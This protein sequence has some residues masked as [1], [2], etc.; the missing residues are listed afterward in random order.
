MPRTR[1]AFHIVFEP[2]AGLALRDA[3]PFQAGVAS[4]AHALP[5][6]PPPGPFWAAGRDALKATGALRPGDHFESRG[7]WLLK[8]GERYFPAPLDLV[9]TLDDRGNPAGWTVMAPV[10]DPGK[11]AMDA[12]RASYAA[13]D[14]TEEDWHQGRVFAWS[15]EQR[16]V[17]TEGRFMSAAQWRTYLRGTA[18]D[19]SLDLKPTEEFKCADDVRVGTELAGRSAKTGRLYSEPVTFLTKG[20]QFEIAAEI[21]S[22]EPREVPGETIVR[23]GGEAKI[24]SVRFSQPDRA[25]AG[26]DDEARKAARGAILRAALPHLLRVKLCL[27]TPAI[28]SANVNALREYAGTAAWRPSWLRDVWTPADRIPLPRWV[29]SS[30]SSSPAVRYET[31]LAAALAG[32]AY[33]LGFWDS[34]LH[35]A[36]ESRVQD[37][38]ADEDSGDPGRGSTKPLYRCLPAGAVYFVELRAVGD[39]P[40]EQALDDFLDR[41]WFRSLLLRKDG[42]LTFFGKMGF[43]VAVAGGWNDAY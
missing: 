10:S 28:Y 14:R 27:L 7:V 11:V 34:E 8:N 5:F 16:V 37:V 43:G 26:F 39:T 6:P 35:R 15:G 41:F 30:H 29:R 17:P 2:I 3:R 18:S 19:I 4:V 12:A 42:V 21:E 31:R 33:P 1:R 25:N 23:L 38:E 32:K 9:T 13:R 22:V 40:L 20:T 36:P 24:A